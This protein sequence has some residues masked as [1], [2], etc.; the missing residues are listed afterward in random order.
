MASGL[1]AITPLFARGDVYLVATSDPDILYD[2][3]ERIDGT[4]G[5]PLSPDG[6]V[7]SM[8]TNGSVTSDN[9]PNTADFYRALATKPAYWLEEHY[10]IVAFFDV[11]DDTVAA[12]VRPW[13][14][15]QHN[16]IGQRAA[17]SYVPVTFRRLHQIDNGV[18]DLSLLFEWLA[19]R[20]TLDRVD[21]L[22]RKLTALPPMPERFMEDAESTASFLE[23]V[24]NTL[25]EAENHGKI[26]VDMAEQLQFVHLWAI[27]AE[28][29][30]K[31]RLEEVQSRWTSMQAC[32]DW[33]D[34]WPSAW[35]DA[36]GSTV[37]LTISVQHTDDYWQHP[38]MLYIS[39]QM[40]QGAGRVREVGTQQRPSTSAP[41]CGHRRGSVSGSCRGE[42]GEC[43]Q[44]AV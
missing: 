24:R 13:L 1:G 35:P 18:D 7:V 25:R 43:R 26:D 30:L 22:E 34:R 8:F 16:M 19:S 20:W 21:S 23:R 32:G 10:D 42:P 37:Y 4:H 14:F 33:V 11:R 41:L 40:A 9:A 28:V 6:P 38:S 2:L 3:A 44:L 29:T 27:D 39:D 5:A 15:L 17:D 31:R 36:V 12:E